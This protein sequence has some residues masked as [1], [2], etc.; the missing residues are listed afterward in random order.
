MP[1]RARSRILSGQ[2]VDS[3]P[4]SAFR[5]LGAL[6]KFKIIDFYGQVRVI[7]PN[8]PIPLFAALNT[9][10]KDQIFLDKECLRFIPNTSVLVTWGQKPT[11]GQL[12]DF[13]TA[14]QNLIF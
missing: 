11:T 12:S 9:S 10:L 1:L 8:S 4:N 2:G 3:A 6:P 5:K 7:K 13:I 14:A